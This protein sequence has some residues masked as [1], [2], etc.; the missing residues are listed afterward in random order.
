MILSPFVKGK[1]RKKPNLPGSSSQ[2]ILL[3]ISLKDLKPYST[4]E[5]NFRVSIAGLPKML[6]GKM[7]P[8]AIRRPESAAG[9]FVPAWEEG[10]G[11]FPR[12][13]LKAAPGAALRVVAEVAGALGS[14]VEG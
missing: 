10:E 3:L 14:L 1:D 9:W 5:Q 11:A 8:S 6:L 12:R 7:S 2:R 4:F 13:A